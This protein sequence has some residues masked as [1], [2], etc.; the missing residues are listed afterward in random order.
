MHWWNE[1]DIMRAMTFG[2]LFA[3]IGGFDLGFERAGMH[4]TWSVEI[5][6]R[7]NEVRTHHWPDV[8]QYKDVRDVG[9]H[10]LEPVDVICGGFPCQDLS[11]AGRRAGLA[12]ERSGLWWEFH[13]I[14]EELQPR[15]AVIE[16]VPGLLSSNSGRDM[17]TIV[18]ALGKLGYGYA[19]ATLDAQYFGLAQRRRRVFIVGCLG[20]WRGAAQ[21]LFEP[22]SGERD[23]APSR[24]TGQSTTNAITKSLGGG[25]PDDNK[26]QGGFLTVANTSCLRNSG[27][28]A[29][30]RDGRTGIGLEDELAYSLQ[31]EQQHAIVQHALSGNNQRNDPDGEHFV[32]SE[33]SKGDSTPVV[34]YGFSQESDGSTARNAKNLARPIT[35]RHGDPGVVAFQQ[36]NYP[37]L[38]T[39]PQQG[40]IQENQVEVSNASIQE[41]NA[42]EVL[43]ILR[44]KVGEE[45]F[46][47]WGLRILDS[48]QQAEILRPLVH[49]KSFRGETQD[50]RPMLDYSALPRTEDSEAGSVQEVW[51]AR[52]LGRASQEWQLE[53]Q[54]TGELGA[55]LSQLSQQGT[56]QATALRD[57]WEATEGLGVLRQALSEIQEM[58]QSLDGETQPTHKAY[59]V[60][61]LTPLEAERLQGFPDTWTAVNGMSDSARYRM[62]GNAVAV[63]VAE[64]IGRRIAEF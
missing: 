23:S 5:D 62:L 64:W 36:Q 60:R 11:V 25:G 10:N 48:L 61:R 57:M 6:D 1:S 54:L 7:C 58:G 44:N 8:R 38:D 45:T 41:T 63:P 59:G 51:V 13:R 18:G 12:G 42:R 39:L 37:R 55:Y 20:D 14:I 47:E 34:A 22:E 15:W 52:C 17:G 56:P 31:A 27:R 50:G 40:I 35:G 28:D 16:N 9:R 46:A 32:I 3:G 43:R 26:A 4:C 29:D 53:G 30:Q 2:S 24:E 21:V 49:G 33:T 19:W